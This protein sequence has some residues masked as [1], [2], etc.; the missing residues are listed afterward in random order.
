MISDEVVDTLK[1]HCRGGDRCCGKEGNRLC[2]EGE[3]DCDH[4]DQCAGHLKCGKNNCAHTSGGYWDP[5]DDCCEKPC[6]PDR[7]C[8]QG[9]GVCNADNECESSGS[10]YS[11]A[12]SCTNRNFFPLDLYPTLAQI[13]GYTDTDKCCLRKCVPYAKCG[14]NAVGCESNQDCQA[15]HECVG[16]GNERKCMDINECTDPR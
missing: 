6:T 12:Q 5:N 1:M 2:G 11:C 14:H 3:G 13:Y 10:F 8:S 7:P 4:D 16:T 9:Q 15:G